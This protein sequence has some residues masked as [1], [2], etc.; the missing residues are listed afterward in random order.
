MVIS[1]DGLSQS[2]VEGRSRG[3]ANV[4]MRRLLSGAFSLL[5]LIEDV[6][7]QMIAL[8]PRDFH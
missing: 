3:V 2:R 7:V 4:F 8:K 5:G 1:P 6:K